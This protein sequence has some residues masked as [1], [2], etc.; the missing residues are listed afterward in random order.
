MIRTLQVTRSDIEWITVSSRRP[1]PV[2]GND[3]QCQV[4]S[5]GEFAACAQRPSDWPMVSGAW[6]HR[7][8]QTAESLP[9]PSPINWRSPDS[10]RGESRHSETRITAA[11]IASLGK[12]TGSDLPRGEAHHVHKRALSNAS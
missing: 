11:G 7:L 12:K 2:C 5:E 3:H 6:L 8:E 4:Q 10:D 1:C 9:A